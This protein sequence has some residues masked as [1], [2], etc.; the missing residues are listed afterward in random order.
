MEIFI[1]PLWFFHMEHYIGT[2]FSTGKGL[3]KNG[4]PGP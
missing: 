2:E 3:I 1:F 4:L